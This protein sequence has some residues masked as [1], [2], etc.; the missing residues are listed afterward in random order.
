MRR[1]NAWSLQS[2]LSSSMYSKN[3]TICK[4]HVWGI[5][6]QR[7]EDSRWV[8]QWAIFC[9][10]QFRQFRTPIMCYI[11]DCEQSLFSQSSLSSAGL[12]RAKWPRGKLESGGKKR[13]CILFCSLLSPPPPQ[14]PLGFLF[15]YFRSPR[16]ISSLAWPS[17]VTDRSLVTSREALHL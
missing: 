9:N 3:Y 15:F 12:E 6:F 17:W 5:S 13:D 4:K 10:K 16:S 8:L 14:L 2:K 7:T 11:L 1:G